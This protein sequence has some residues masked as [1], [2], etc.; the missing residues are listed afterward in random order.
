LPAAG[1]PA[2]ISFA[3]AAGCALD[4]GRSLLYGEQ[5]QLKQRS[6]TLVGRMAKTKR[7]EF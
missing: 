6:E 3:R 1:R 4:K 5:P 2:R 7:Q